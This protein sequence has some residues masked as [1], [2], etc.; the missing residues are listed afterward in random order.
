[1]GEA[2]G[3]DHLSATFFYSVGLTCAMASGRST[4]RIEDRPSGMSMR[5]LFLFFAV[6]CFALLA[7]CET[8]KPQAQSE[9]NSLIQEPA[10]GHEI[11]GEIGAMYG[12]SASRH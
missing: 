12:Q 10:S 7:G 2:I 5:F 4:Y 6:S 11:H 8:S 3:I 1:V 9:A